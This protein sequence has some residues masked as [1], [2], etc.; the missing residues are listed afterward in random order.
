M[1]IL[2]AIGSI[3]MAMFVIALIVFSIIC[4]SAP[5]QALATF[6][7]T[8]FN[9]FIPATFVLAFGLLI[10]G[11]GAFFVLEFVENAKTERQAFADTIGPTIAAGTSPASCSACSS[12][13]PCSTRSPNRAIGIIR[14]LVLRVAVPARVQVVARWVAQAM[15]VVQALALAAARSAAPPRPTIPRIGTTTM[16][17]PRRR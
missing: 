13:S 11:I 14:R 2:G 1:G 5:G 17:G 7:N 4:T 10:A 9:N 15:A 8:V 16:M 6:I 3:M 12:S